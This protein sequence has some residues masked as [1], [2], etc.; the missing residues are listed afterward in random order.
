M[1]ANPLD[2]ALHS[3]KKAAELAKTDP[4]VIEL[5]SRPKRT[6][7]FTFPMRMDNGEVN[8]FTAYRVHWCDALGTFKDGTRFT[9][10]LTLDELK[11]LALWM[12]IKHAVGGIPAGGSK[13][14][15]VVEPA[16]LS[17]WEL[18]RL[19]RSF[20]RNLP[21]KGAWI[22]VPGA[23]IG[24]GEQ[25][26]AWMLDEYESIVGF[27]SPAAVND[28]PAAV[29][30]TVGSSEATG[31]GAFYVFEQVVNDFSFDRKCSVAVQGY[32]KVGSVFANL[33]YENG[34]K[35][36]AVSDIRGGIYN[37]DGIDCSRLNEYVA[38]KGSVVYFPGT[39]AVSN[40]ELLELEADILVPAAVQSV[41][42]GKNAPNIKAK[43]IIEAANGPVS[44]DAEEY[45][46]KHNIPVIPDVVANVGGAIVCHFERIQGLT[47]EYWDIDRVRKQLKEWILKA[48]QQMTDTAGAH[49]TTYRMAAWINALQKIEASIKKRGW[50]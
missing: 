11:A 33:L 17:R 5:L 38:E 40:N 48:Y 21:I 14:G 39:E 46:Y 28:K 12:T 9:G 34:Y 13:G 18:E 47:D 23:D 30:G 24:T 8:I 43:L 42:D 31:T 2:T 49:K 37:S 22:D 3:L 50:V 45:L 27:H 10:N 15:V 44:P 36:V 6:I 1:G 26:Q 41:I 25:T 16:E 20:M 29:S 7:E 35:V 4:K 32:G 19:A